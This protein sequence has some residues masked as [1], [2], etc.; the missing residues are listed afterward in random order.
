MG[1]R[2]ASAPPPPPPPPPPA[3]QQETKPNAPSSDESS[4]EEA[5]QATGSQEGARDALPPS[6]ETAGALANAESALEAPPQNVTVGQ[7]NVSL[8]PSGSPTRQQEQVTNARR[9]RRRDV[10]SADSTGVAERMETLKER[11]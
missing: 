11:L 9:E 7:R 1:A 2:K 8:S 5:P 6:A 3:A 10:G 4:S